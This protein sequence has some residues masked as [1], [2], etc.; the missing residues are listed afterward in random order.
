[1]LSFFHITVG[2]RVKALAQERNGFRSA[3]QP[4]GSRFSHGECQANVWRCATWR[5]VACSYASMARVRARLVDAAW[6]AAGVHPV[7]M[8]EVAGVEA[9]K[10]MAEAGVAVVPWC[11]GAVVPCLAVER[12]AVAGCLRALERDA[13]GNRLA[14]RLLRHVMI[15]VSGR[16]T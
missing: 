7:E 9:L 3:L 12:E 8:L 15:V 11:R 13:T 4:L 2:V 1:M 5:C 10:R 14:Y 6:R 16:W